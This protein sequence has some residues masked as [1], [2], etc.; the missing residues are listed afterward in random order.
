MIFLS[1]LDVC[2]DLGVVDAKQLARHFTHDELA[3]LYQ[4]DFD[5]DDDLIVEYD[6]HRIQDGILRHLIQHYRDTVVSYLEHDSFLMHRDEE[7]LTT[8]EKIQASN[9]G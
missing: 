4:F 6:I 1:F 8:E 2:L 3:Q 7:N 5:A 9:E